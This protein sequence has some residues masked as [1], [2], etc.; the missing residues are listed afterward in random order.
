MN[1]ALSLSHHELGLVSDG[2]RIMVIANAKDSKTLM[3]TVS[4]QQDHTLEL[5]LFTLF[6]KIKLPDINKTIELSIREL[7]LMKRG[8]MLLAGYFYKKS[9]TKTEKNRTEYYEN[10]NLQF[11]EIRHKIN[12]MESYCIS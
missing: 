10:Y 1:D 5:E 12:R 7:K 9:L 8:L 6:S 11:I 4:K 3:E 2:L